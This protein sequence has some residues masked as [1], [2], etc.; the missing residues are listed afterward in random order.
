MVKQ[1]WSLSCK[2]LYTLFW[3][4]WEELPRHRGPAA[5]AVA[6]A[7]ILGYNWAVFVERDGGDV[8]QEGVLGCGGVDGGVD[9]GDEEGWRCCW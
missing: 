9:G 6:V 4:C 5:L 7:A 2:Q 8:D 3:R 1:T